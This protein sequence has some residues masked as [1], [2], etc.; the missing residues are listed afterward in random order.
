MVYAED[1]RYFPGSCCGQ[2]SEYNAQQTVSATHCCTTQLRT[3]PVPGDRPG[4]DGGGRQEG[5]PLLPLG[6]PHQLPHHHRLELMPALCQVVTLESC[7]LYFSAAILGL[8]HFN[9]PN[10]F[11]SP[12]QHIPLTLP[13]RLESCSF[14]P[15]SPTIRFGDVHPLFSSFKGDRPSRRPKLFGSPMVSNNSTGWIGLNELCFPCHTCVV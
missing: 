5:L 10:G 4:G 6:L 9:N 1:D 7:L 8:L 11:Q 13:Q 15:L 2:L 14:T 3:F 12:F